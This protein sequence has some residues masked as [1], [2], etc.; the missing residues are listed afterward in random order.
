MYQGEDDPYFD[1]DMVKELSEDKSNGFI[2]NIDDGTIE[3][4]DSVLAGT[5]YLRAYSEVSL[6]SYWHHYMF[7]QFDV[8]DASGYNYGPPVFE[9]DPVD[10]K[11]TT[12]ILYTYSFPS[13]SDPDGDSYT[14]ELTGVPD[15][16]TYNEIEIEC[17]SVDY[18]AM[19]YRG[20]YVIGVTIED[21]RDPT[22][23][24]ASST[25]DFTIK[26]TDF[27]EMVD[28]PDEV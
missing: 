2:L 1:G 26:I 24:Q 28:A 14:F 11:F 7:L 13:I 10:G 8:L 9:S 16:C 5:Y 15:F 17:D 3:L 23:L 22:T 19:R 18:G 6:N 25:Y 21:I 20:E 4:S 27:V 12:G